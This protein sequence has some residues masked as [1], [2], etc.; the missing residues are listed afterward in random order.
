VAGL[1]ETFQPFFKFLWDGCESFSFVYFEHFVVK[2]LFTTKSTKNT[3]GNERSV[4][5]E[6]VSIDEPVTGGNR[7][8]R[9]GFVHER[10]VFRIAG[11]RC[12]S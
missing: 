12:L 4:Y 3:K 1:H 5:G 10:S 6:Q 11:R 2:N 9:L 8:E 7:R